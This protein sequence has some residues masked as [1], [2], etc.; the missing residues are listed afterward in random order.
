MC[1]IYG[2]GPNRYVRLC[3]RK[4]HLRGV[5]IP[6][7]ESD[8]WDG[9]GCYPTGAARKPRDTDRGAEPE[10]RGPVGRCWACGRPFYSKHARGRTE[11][12][13][14]CEAAVYKWADAG[15]PETERSD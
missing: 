2:S 1:R 3:C 10:S 13:P 8:P 14:P 6:L 9:R 4:G 7:P 15:K 11:C 5:H 12:D